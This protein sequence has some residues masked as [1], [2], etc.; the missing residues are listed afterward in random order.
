MSKTIQQVKKGIV[1]VHKK[2]LKDEPD[3]E[4]FE[5]AMDDMATLQNDLVEVE[6]E[7]ASLKDN[8]NE[9][10]LKISAHFADV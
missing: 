5:K 9:M 4:Q 3:L 10:E 2:Y 8:L 7:V 1:A 6:N